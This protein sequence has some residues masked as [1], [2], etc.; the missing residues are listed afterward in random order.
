MGQC[1][2][3]GDES[4]HSPDLNWEEDLLQQACWRKEWGKVPTD[5]SR[6]QP[7]SILLRVLSGY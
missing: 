2:G 7:L 3:E 5:P 6:S 4:S 1:C